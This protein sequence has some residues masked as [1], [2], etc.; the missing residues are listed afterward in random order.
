VPLT[1]ARA[2]EGRVVAQAKINLFLR[3]LGR[4]TDGYHSIETLF[5]RLEIGDIVRLRVGDGAERAIHCHGPA[6]PAEGLGPAEGNLAYRAAVAYAEATGWPRSFAI[7]IEKHVP[8][9]GGLGGGSADAG[10]VLRTLEAMS[11]RPAGSETIGRIAARLGSDVPFFAS[12]SACAL[13]WGRGERMLDVKPPPRR[14]VGLLVPSFGVAT[15]WA[16]EQLATTWGGMAPRS[17]LHR[18]G[19]LSSWERLES[20]AVNDLEPVV[21]ARHPEIAACVV[22]LR[23]RNARIAMMSG[24]GSTVFGIFDRW[25]DEVSDVPAT[26]TSLRTRTATRVVGVELSE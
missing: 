24:S 20:L 5:L 25:A 6:H 3:V 8:V 11:P 26:V 2:V 10:A 21:S 1:R 12:E 4:E 14:Q 22:A 13:A 23:A 18:I 16:Y 15:K 9:S 7:E 19:E 17:V